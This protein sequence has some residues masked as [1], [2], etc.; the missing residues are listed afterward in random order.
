MTKV[1]TNQISNV[2]VQEDRILTRKDRIIPFVATTGLN[3]CRNRV[4]ILC[5]NQEILVGGRL[6]HFWQNWE[7]KTTTIGFYKGI[8]W[9]NCLQIGLKSK[10]V[11]MLCV[12]LF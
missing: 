2:L 11:I 8:K 9:E 5:Q 12:G 3:D 7:K 1:V 6:G 10:Q 4:N